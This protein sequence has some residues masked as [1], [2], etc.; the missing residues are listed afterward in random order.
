MKFYYLFIIYLMVLKPIFNQLTIDWKI[1]ISSDQKTIDISNKNHLTSTNG[2]EKFSSTL[3]NISITYCSLTNT[4]Y[5]KYLLKLK[6]LNLVRN[7]I[8]DISSLANLHQLEEL[9]LEFNKISNIDTLE[10]LTNLTKL[11]LENNQIRSIR[12]LNKLKKLN[13]LNLKSN[14][15]DKFDIGNMTFFEMT[16]LNLENNHID[17]IYEIPIMMPHLRELYLAGNIIKDISYINL[18]PNLVHFSGSSNN[19][20]KIEENVCQ[21]KNL[22]S[23]IL[24][25]NSLD[26]IDCLSLTNK[27][28]TIVSITTNNIENIDS[29]INGLTS[30][31]SLEANN[32]K[33]RQVNILNTTNPKMTSLELGY[34]Q[35]ENI[36]FLSKLTLI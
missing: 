30:L 15:L 20:L 2:I 9:D 13:F 28:L 8:N 26:N 4:K 6:V 18:L 27:N 1:H 11:D 36:D 33:I 5:L 17:T 35:L 25:D 22:Q 12:K 34:N 14:L 24:D 10:N 32:N 29:I 7:L 23:V 19:I 3:T 21:L 16:T 31:N